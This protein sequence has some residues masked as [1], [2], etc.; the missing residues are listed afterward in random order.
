MIFIP[1][2]GKGILLLTYLT[3]FSRIISEPS[4][5]TTIY[6]IHQQRQGLLG[7]GSPMKVGAR[8]PS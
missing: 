5:C 1:G 3:Y 6:I 7:V 8:L 4:Q 2:L